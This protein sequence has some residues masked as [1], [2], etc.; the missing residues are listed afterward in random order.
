MTSE[1]PAMGLRGRKWLVL[2]AC[3]LGLF[4]VIIDNTVVN[5]AIASMIA[6]LKANLAQIEWVLNAYALSFA[7][8]LITFGR[9]G[10]LYGRR[11]LFLIGLAVF[12]VGSAACGLAPNAGALIAF[13]VFQSVGSA[14]ML[15]GT[16][17]LVTVTFPPKERGAAF[18]IWGAVSGF[19]VG[20]G[21]TVG[22][23]LTQISWR[24]IFFINVPIVIFAFIFTLLVV[25]E[26]R[27]AR[28]QHV[29]WIGVV[30]SIAF[31]VTFNYGMIQGPQLEWN[32]AII[33]LIVA[34]GALFAGFLIWERFPMH[35]LVELDLWKNRSYAAGNVVAFLLLF[36]MFGVFFLVP[37]FL[38]TIL[39]FGA[40]KTGLVIAPMSVAL[41]LVGPPAGRL[42]DKYG[43]RWLMF[44][45][46]LIISAG[47]LWIS[48]LS[49]TMTLGM[50]IPRFVL[51]GVGMGLV[52]SPMT[53]AVMASVPERRAGGASGVLTT[54][55][56]VGAVMGI[57]VLGAVLQGQLASAFLTRL[58][59]LPGVSG[60]QALEIV[61]L[62]RQS[63]T[64]L[65]GGGAAAAGD[66]PAVVLGEREARVLRSRLS[67]AYSLAF[68]EALST[69]LRL[70]SLVSF[71]AALVALGVSANLSA[72]GGTRAPPEGI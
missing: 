7:A 34:S 3:S 48:N 70:S 12:G 14:C 5:I 47:T 63:R 11:L 21:P 42:A 6:D 49:V 37:L 44:A 29:D 10:D 9:F 51:T 52:I 4:M 56:Q 16:L 65:V 13:R 17:S 30:L 53:T 32:A 39:G 58:T 46:L 50:L 45:G 33:G 23:L 66:V 8:L 62:E 71:A 43:P 19:A 24:Y 2:A 26:S 27:D 15:P 20:I 60:G 31:L 18:G 54:M 40:L 38:Q 61:Q 59:A 25:T 1:A 55:R 64:G 35:P 22:G 41:M 36:A 68:I 67:G 57:A 69:A 28:K 72:G